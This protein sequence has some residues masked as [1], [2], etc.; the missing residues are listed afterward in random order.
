MNA[1]VTSQLL[2]EVIYQRLRLDIL[3]GALQRG[4]LLRQEELAQSFQV[5]RVPLREALSRL[6]AEG[7]IVLRPRRGYAV[8]SLDLGAIIEIFELRAVVEEHAGAVA[9]R[10]RTGQDVAEVEAILAKMEALKPKAAGFY[11][12]W[13]R[14]NREFHAR[15]IAASHRGRVS[16]LAANLLDSVEPYVRAEAEHRTTGHVRDADSEHRQMFVAF[17]AGDS[18]KL[19]ALGRKHVDS[20]AQRLLDNMRRNAGASSHP[21]KKK[22]SQKR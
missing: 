9:A 7:L 11:P 18:A 20:A 19:A 3:N 14:Y 15:I 6:E 16:R 12:E 5:S 21:S 22:E 13:F 17:K 1:P 4:Q 2:S 8:T 10:S